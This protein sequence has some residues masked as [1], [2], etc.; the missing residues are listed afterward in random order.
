M[1]SRWKQYLFYASLIIIGGG[2]IF[3]LVETVKAKN[4][5]FETKTLWDWMELLIIP[6]VLAIGAF[7]LNRSESAVERQIAEDRRKE[8]RKLAEDRA[9]LDYDIA[10]DHQRDAALQSYFD[11]M[12]E[13]LL[14]EKLRTT[15]KK[16]VHDVART[17]TL[18]V[19]RGLSSRRKGNVII[20]LQETKLIKTP[21]PVVE[22]WGSDLQEC[23]LHEADLEATV[24]RG[25]NFENA[26][27]SIAGLQNADL[28]R[29]NLTG[30][31]L[32]GANL[33]G[34]DL[35]NAELKNANLQNAV[36]IDAKISDLQLA[37][38]KSL[39]GATKPDGT[40]QE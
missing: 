29:A 9:K 25:V 14:K 22:L 37:T 1:N 40:K 7:F 3:I 19:L 26:N 20:F 35:R 38:V 39:K 33:C 11:R 18:T 5:G 32:Y 4:T 31:F 34:A 27:L 17:W 12:S 16:E 10:L 8:D 21:N 36:L 13:L 6:L 24:L 30:A 15:K 23:D 28:R 2:L